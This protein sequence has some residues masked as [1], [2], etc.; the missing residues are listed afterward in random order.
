MRT[1]TT[2]LSRH[3]LSNLDEKNKLKE[4]EEAVELLS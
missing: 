2:V 3:A 4:D 1:S